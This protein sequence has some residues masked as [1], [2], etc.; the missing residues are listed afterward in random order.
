[1]D[2]LYQINKKLVLKNK[3]ILIIGCVLSLL[4][5]NYIV[6]AFFNM[7]M[8]IVMVLLGYSY[9]NVHVLMHKLKI[10]QQFTEFQLAGLNV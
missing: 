4:L 9:M 3:F 5:T 6:T 1:M 2:F 7:E 8:S 10:R